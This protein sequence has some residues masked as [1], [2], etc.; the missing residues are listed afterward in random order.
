M[1]SGDGQM[2]FF[3][4]RMPMNA[5]AGMGAEGGIGGVYGAEATHRVYG[6]IDMQVKNEKL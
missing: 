4:G 2:E 5:E 6:S 1:C 3:H